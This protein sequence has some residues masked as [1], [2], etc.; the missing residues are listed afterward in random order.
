MDSGLL[1]A[2]VSLEEGTLFP[3]HY[4]IRS[5]DIG[6]LKDDH[7]PNELGWEPDHIK[8]IEHPWMVHQMWEMCFMHGHK[9]G[10][11]VPFFV[12]WNECAPNRTHPRG[13]KSL[14]HCEHQADTRFMNC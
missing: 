9:M 10:G 2:L 5:D 13:W 8:M 1:G 11:V 6:D 14:F 3:Y 4:A 7:I 12:D